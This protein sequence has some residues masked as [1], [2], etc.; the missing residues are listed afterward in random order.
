MNWDW[1]DASMP[2]VKPGNDKLPVT[3][4]GYSEAK[5]YCASLGRRLPTEIEWQFA[6]QGN[7]NGSDGE[8]LLYPWGMTD[9]ATLRPNMTTGNIFEGPE[10][11]DRYSPAGDSV[12][13]LKSMV[14][15][16]W[17]VKL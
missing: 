3:Y 14:G 11:V 17:Q 7:L 9:N 4:I 15:N 1:S 5:A 16:V 8:A 6:G 12:F 13:G 10:P 2:K